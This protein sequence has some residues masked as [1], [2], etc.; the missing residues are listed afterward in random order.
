MTILEMFGQSAILAVLGMIVV[1]CFLW[2]MI[3]CV[4]ITGKIIS[5]TESGK[6]AQQQEKN[7]F[8][9]TGSTVKPEIVAAISAALT[10]H[11]ESK[12]G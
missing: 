9:S 11:R 4:S 2:L 10:E 12:L 7:T 5:K 8:N 3:I 1:F 6:D